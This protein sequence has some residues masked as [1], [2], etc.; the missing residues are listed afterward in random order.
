[1]CWSS[2]TQRVI[3]FFIFIKK[4]F[5]R[6]CSCFYQI[7]QPWTESDWVQGHPHHAH[8][9][10]YW[11]PLRW[12]KPT[13][14]TTAGNIDKPLFGNNYSK[15]RFLWFKEHNPNRIMPVQHP[16]FKVR[17]VL[18]LTHDGCILVAEIAN[19]VTE[20]LNTQ[21]YFRMLYN[22]IEVF[23]QCYLVNQIPI[24]VEAHPNEFMNSNN[25]VLTPAPPIKGQLGLVILQ[26]KME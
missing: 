23:Q 18:I 26:L 15:K 3:S 2:T 25:P 16:T 21:S 19:K 1:M 20:E 14:W 17:D 11:E 7:L 24:Q 5:L 13:H 6:G 8:C 22:R 12:N 10:W 4:H 9:E